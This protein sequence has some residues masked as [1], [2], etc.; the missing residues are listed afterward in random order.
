MRFSYQQMG[1]SALVDPFTQALEFGLSKMVQKQTGD[2][3]VAGEIGKRI[4]KKSPLHLPQPLSQ[5]SG[6]SHFLAVAK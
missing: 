5:T 1:N 2:Q 3:S 6:L 4:E